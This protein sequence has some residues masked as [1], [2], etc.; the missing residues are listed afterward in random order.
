MNRTISDVFVVKAQM[1]DYSHIP[2][3]NGGC[4][5]ESSE[6]RSREALASETRHDTNDGG[7]GRSKRN[8]GAGFSTLEDDFVPFG[9]RY[10]TPSP[11][12]TLFFLPTSKFR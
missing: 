3:T 12:F 8:R 9:S 5:W 6:I 7:W 10:L 11:H 1:P 2:S 4:R